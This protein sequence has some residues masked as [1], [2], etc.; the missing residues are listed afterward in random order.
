MA[1]DDGIIL[2]PSMN[3]MICSKGPD[4]SILSCSAAEWMFWSGL[5]TTSSASGTCE[6]VES[7]GPTSAKLWHRF[8]GDIR[9]DFSG[10]VRDA[11][12]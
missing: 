5:V 3:V 1:S 10:R 8:R 6:A 7:V 2:A 11:S 4:C 12:H 9:P